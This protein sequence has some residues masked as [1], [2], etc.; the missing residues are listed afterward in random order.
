MNAAEDVATRCVYRVTYWII[1][2]LN[3]GHTYAEIRD[4]A[5]VHTTNGE[6]WVV[7]DEAD[8]ALA[9]EEARRES[10]REEKRKQ[11]IDDKSKV[12][13]TVSALLLTANVAL[14]PHLPIRWFGFIPL[15]FVLAA[16]FLTLMYFRTDRTGVVVPSKVDWTDR[17]KTRLALAR[18][19]FTCAARMGPRNDLRVGVHKA[20]RRAL[21]LALAAMALV[22]ISLAI[23]K[24]I[25]PL[26]RRIQTDAEVRRLLQGPVGPVGPS[27]PRGAVG[28]PGPRG[29]PGP[30]G[31][32]GPPGQGGDG[33]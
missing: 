1:F 24:P 12:M 11:A 15:C 30:I 3:P 33:K 29:L 25:D 19:E 7:P 4:G 9:L 20:A 28:Q 22:L 16:V 13:L 5:M 2:I 18:S 8:P 23:V 32:A 26:V 14:L 27:G 10:E 21:L 17:D 6:P 31:P